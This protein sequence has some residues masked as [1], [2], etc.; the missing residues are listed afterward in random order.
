[1]ISFYLDL[2]LFYLTIISF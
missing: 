2:S 1:L